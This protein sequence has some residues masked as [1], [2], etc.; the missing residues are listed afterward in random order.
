MKKW[1][2]DESITVLLAMVILTTFVFGVLTSI[3]LAQTYV[4]PNQSTVAW[5]IVDGATGYNVYVAPY[6]KYEEKVLLGTT[7]ELT[8]VVTIPTDLPKYVV[9]V[10]SLID[11]LESDVNWSDM[12]GAATP[13]P[14]IYINLRSPLNFRIP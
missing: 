10:T 14:F 13:N 2:N 4:S 11:N 9:G 12:N 1:I 6:Q 5:D 8:Y 7:V 3:G